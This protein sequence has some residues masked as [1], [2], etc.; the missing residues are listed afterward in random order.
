MKLR[1]IN[2]LFGL[3]SILM[4]TETEKSFEMVLDDVNS[5]QT[6]KTS[7]M[8]VDNFDRID[9]SKGLPVNLTDL[10]LT[11]ADENVQNGEN[12]E[13]TDE[14]V[15]KNEENGESSVLKNDKIDDADEKL[16][17]NSPPPVLSREIG[18]NSSEI[19]ENSLENF[20]NSAE[21]LENSLE[22]LENSLEKF[23]N[24]AENLETS[25]ETLESSMETLENSAENLENSAENLENQIP[26]IIVVEKRPRNDNNK[27]E[28]NKKQENDNFSD[29]SSVCEVIDDDED[30]LKIEK[31][32]NNSPETVADILKAAI[33]YSG[34]VTDQEF[35]ESFLKFFKTRLEASDARLIDVI[36]R[37]FDE[38][39]KSRPLGVKK[40]L[41]NGKIAKPSAIFEP[42]STVVHLLAEFQSDDSFTT[43]KEK[44]R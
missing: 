6:A 7:S 37:F 40:L 36:R 3:G 43:L 14:T 22:I 18:E 32:Q 29:S 17:E 20:E 16:I 5:N 39:Y 38:Q 26:D 9:F 13:K 11:A 41:D 42:P 2:F 15:E 19:L 23:E 31:V 35:V 1:K 10:G 33:S 4:E 44:F 34:A 12:F 30:D 28:T 21:I 24:S 8:D 25:A 27:L